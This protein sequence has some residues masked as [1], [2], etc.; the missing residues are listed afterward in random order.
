[1]LRENGKMTSQ[2]KKLLTVLGVLILTLVLFTGTALADPATPGNGVNDD[3]NSSRLSQMIEWMGPEN[4]GQMIQRM[5][6]IHG[7]EQTGQMLQW[8]N[9]SGNCHN[10]DGAG[11]MMGRGLGGGMGFGFG[12]RMWNNN[13]DEQ[14]GQGLNQ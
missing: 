8:M 2:M 7:A 9:Q 14:I 5:T 11:S 6:Q 4:W 10:F 13:V 12:S 3:N 1:M